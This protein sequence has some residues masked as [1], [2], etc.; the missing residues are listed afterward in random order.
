MQTALMMEQEVGPARSIRWTFGQGGRLSVCLSAFQLLPPGPEALPFSPCTPAIWG[1]VANITPIKTQE[2]FHGVALA[3]GAAPLL[4]MGHH[5]GE[6]SHPPPPA[7]CWHQCQAGSI[8]AFL[9]EPGTQARVFSKLIVE[10]R[11]CEALG[12]FEGPTDPP[13]RWPIH[14]RLPGNNNQEK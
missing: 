14:S 13:Q 12:L 6:Q 8:P 3:D 4:S 9:V 10:K 7:S 2:R 11:M 1:A 5:L